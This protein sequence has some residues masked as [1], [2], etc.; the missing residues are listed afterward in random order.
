MANG[1]G[2][3]GFAL[4]KWPASL[5]R[6]PFPPK[7]LLGDSRKLRGLSVS[8]G[9]QALDAAERLTPATSGRP[10]VHRL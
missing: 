5:Q 7:L 8:V 1:G 2:G 6:N 9:Q 3:G 10:P 4:W